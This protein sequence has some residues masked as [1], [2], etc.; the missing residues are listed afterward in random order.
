[1]PDLAATAAEPS[2]AATELARRFGAIWDL[3]DAGST[4]EAIARRTDQPIGQ[5]ELILGLRRR[6]VAAEARP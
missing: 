3:A 6:L 5:V 2:P 1:M 4:A